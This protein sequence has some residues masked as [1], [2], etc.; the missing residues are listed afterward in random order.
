MCRRS[1]RNDFTSFSLSLSAFLSPIRTSCSSTESG[2]TG[3]TRTRSSLLFAAAPPAA[4]AAF[5]SAPFD[6]DCCWLVL[7]PPRP[8]F[9][10]RRDAWVMCGGGCCCCCCCCAGRLL[11]TPPLGPAVAPAAA[12]SA[13]ESI[14][15]LSTTSKR[16]IFFSL[17]LFRSSGPPFLHP[18]FQKFEGKK[19]LNS[20]LLRFDAKTMVAI[21]AGIASSSRA[22]LQ[23][24]ASSL[25]SAAATATPPRRR[26]IAA[27]RATTGRT[28]GAAALSSSPIAALLLPLPSSSSSSSTATAR[29][30]ESLTRVAA[31]PAT[32]FTEAE[33]EVRSFESEK[34]GREGRKKESTGD[35][36]CVAAAASNK[37]SRSPL[38]PLH[39]PP[40]KKKKN[41]S[42]PRPRPPR[43]RSSTA[44]ARP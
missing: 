1:S 32:A 31:V 22:Q 14:S 39:L 24:R 9:F 35:D 5:A 30:R 38:N 2:G 10:V 33:T 13:A 17:S 12:R 25:A 40:P 37:T 15:A 41:L 20:P 18:L 3:T 4:P 34:L 36:G 11:E 28:S 44:S 23:Q 42:R 19:K 21:D 16:V 26:R 7:R 29:R 43:P 27:A 8:F 6:L